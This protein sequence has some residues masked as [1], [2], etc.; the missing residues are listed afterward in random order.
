MRGFLKIEQL[1]PWLRKA[2]ESEL[3]GRGIR[4]FH[5]PAVNAPTQSGPCT[6]KQASVLSRHGRPTNVSYAEAAALIQA[7]NTELSSKRVPA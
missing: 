1:Q 3:Q 5:R 4:D 7:I 2:I 6:E